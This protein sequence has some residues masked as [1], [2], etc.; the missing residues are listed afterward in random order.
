M[1]RLFTG[2]R[3]GVLLFIP[4][5]IVCFFLFNQVTHY[6]NQEN[7]DFGIWNLTG[8][9]NKMPFWLNV[10]FISF[11]ALG[12]NILFNRNEFLDKNTFIVALL[13]VLILSLFPNFYVLDGNLVA[14]TLTTLTLNQ[15]FKLNQN[16]D[17]RKHIFNGL[18]LFG[19]AVTFFPPLL[20]AVP[21]IIFVP[22]IIRPL[23]IRELVIGFTGLILPLAYGF[24]YLHFG[25]QFDNFYN[26][27]VRFSKETLE[28][29]DLLVLVIFG[30]LFFIG[31]TAMFDRIS[32]SSIRLKKQVQILI[33]FTVLSI[34]FGIINFILKNQIN[35]LAIISVPFSFILTFAFHLKRFNKIAAIFFYLLLFYSILKFFIFAPS[36]GN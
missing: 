24:L 22:L 17:G 35:W 1:I 3:F 2:N 16:S 20:L 12:I 28:T 18:F 25:N 5:I 11:N 4:I 7:P 9:L 15:F 36:G 19:T 6:Y 13:Y 32:K 27:N 29:D 30:L 10:I 23:V 31:F 21:I 26:Q 8:F 33:V 14:Q 34:G